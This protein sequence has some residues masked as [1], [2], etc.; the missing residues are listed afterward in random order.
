MSFYRLKQIEFVLPIFLSFLYV[1]GTFLPRR[2]GN[3]GFQ[4]FGAFSAIPSWK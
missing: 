3:W 1:Y 2:H 4:V